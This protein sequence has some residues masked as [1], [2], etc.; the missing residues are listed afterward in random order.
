MHCQFAGRENT[1][2]GKDM[3]ITRNHKAED[4]ERA[5]KRL[6]DRVLDEPVPDRLKELM[7]KLARQNGSNDNGKSENDNGDS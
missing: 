5:L 7:N 4:A 6:Y 3:I 1:V 2:Q